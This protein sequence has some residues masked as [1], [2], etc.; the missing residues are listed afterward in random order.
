VKYG[1]AKRSYEYKV[2]DTE[3]NLKVAPLTDLDSV[4]SVKPAPDGS[5]LV[6]WEGTFRRADHSEKPR[7]GADDAT[8]KKT[9]SGTFASGLANI[10]AKTEGK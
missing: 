6:T 10:K 2:P 8:T 7:A 3:A 5:S 9:V 1:A 4:V